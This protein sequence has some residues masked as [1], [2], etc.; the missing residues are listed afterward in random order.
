MS[1][2]H[3]AG[4]REGEARALVSLAQHLLRALAEVA[5]IGEQP[6]AS[7]LSGTETKRIHGTYVCHVEG[8]HHEASEVLDY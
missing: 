7:G 1:L 3:A 4:D 5:R 8:A 2:N 6:S